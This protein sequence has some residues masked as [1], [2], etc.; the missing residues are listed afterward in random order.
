MKNFSERHW[1]SVPQNVDSPWFRKRCVQICLSMCILIYCT[2]MIKEQDEFFCL[3]L[4]RV[5]LQML[6]QCPSNCWSTLD[7]IFRK[8]KVT[9]LSM[10]LI[11]LQHYSEDKKNHTFSSKTLKLNLEAQIFVKL[12]Q[13]FFMVFSL[14]S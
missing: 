12:E 10:L 4:S 7:K 6:T 3:S 5:P 8:Q 2:F 9:A 14:F 1:P 13:I 11:V